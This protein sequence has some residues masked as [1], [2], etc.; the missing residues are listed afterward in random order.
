[1]TQ[2]EKREHQNRLPQGI[3]K[4]IPARFRMAKKTLPRKHIQI[5]SGIIIPSG[6][7]REALH[8]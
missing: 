5:S 2:Q 1:M 4:E 8:G 7:L 3:F 6:R